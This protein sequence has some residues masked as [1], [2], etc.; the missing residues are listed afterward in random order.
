[1]NQKHDRCPLPAATL[2]KASFWRPVSHARA[3]GDPG[4]AVLRPRHQPTQNKAHSKRASRLFIRQPYSKCVCT[5]FIAKVRTRRKSWS[6]ADCSR[7]GPRI[8]TPTKPRYTLSEMAN[9]CACGIITPRSREWPSGQLSK[10]SKR[11]L[12]GCSGCTRRT[13]LDQ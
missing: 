12:S 13:S 8:R 11:T 2:L 6:D 10:C 5:I 9:S 7:Q 1:M 4:E 3:T